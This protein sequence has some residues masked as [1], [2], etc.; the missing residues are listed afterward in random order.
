MNNKNTTF[1]ETRVNAEFAIRLDHVGLRVADLEKTVP[2]YQEILRMNVLSMVTG[3]Y[4]HLSFAGSNRKILSLIE[5]ESTSQ[6]AMLGHPGERG[7]FALEVAT[8]KGFYDFFKR[9]KESNR[10]CRFKA[11]DH[12]VSWTIYVDDPDSNN[13]E[14]FLWRNSENLQD[15]VA[16]V[17]VWRGATRFLAE[18]AIE[19]EYRRYYS[20]SNSR[21]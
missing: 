21:S 7:H 20:D 9:V 17:A 8:L 12:E 18:E 11:I 14:V 2:F 16:P 19:E 15:E 6:T 10:E 1:L 3:D 13:I 4:A 5:E